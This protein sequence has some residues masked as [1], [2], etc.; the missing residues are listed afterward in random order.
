MKNVNNKDIP[1]SEIKLL[2]DLRDQIDLIDEKLVH[3]FDD[4]AALVFKVGE[5]KKKNNYEIHDPDREKKILDKV[6]KHKLSNLNNYE[7]QSLFIKLMEFFRNTEKAHALISQTKAKELFPQKGTFGFVGF[8]LIGASTGLAL[9]KQF[10]EWKFLVYDPNLKNDE[11]EKW[12]QLNASNLSAK[13]KFEI[14]NLEQLK[15]LDYLFLA[16]PIDINQEL[17]NK[18]VKQ[19]KIVLNLGSFQENIK[20]VIGFHPLAGKEVSGYQSAQSDL[21]YN[22]VICITHSEFCPKESITLIQELAHL[23]GADDFVTSNENH[24][25]SLAYTSHMIQILS[26]VFGNTLEAQGFNEKIALIPGTAKEFL[27]LTG[28]DLKMWEPIIKR[29]QKNILK[30]FSEFEKNWRE[31]RSV[32]QQSNDESNPNNQQIETTKDSFRKVNS[33]FKNL[34]D[35]FV[36]SHEV[37]KK[38]YQKKGSK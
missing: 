30:A 13:S 17:S 31:I 21:F 19:N 4:R 5:W 2:Q 20:D 24:N 33:H 25:L 28:S 23:M 38:L 34:K 11:F 14:V 6:S 32:I 26:M 12:N 16:A 8:G 1:N 10:P 27:R 29:N 9:S 7:I 37:Y 36:H 15:D 22:K 35:L 3:L 18:L